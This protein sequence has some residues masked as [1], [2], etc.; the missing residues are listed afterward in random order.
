[1]KRKP[2]LAA[3]GDM[4]SDWVRYSIQDERGLYWTGRGFPKDKRKALAYADEPVILRGTRRILKRRC[5]GADSVSA[6]RSRR[7]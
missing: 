3:V 5:K 1:M 7:Y 6:C 2:A 4:E